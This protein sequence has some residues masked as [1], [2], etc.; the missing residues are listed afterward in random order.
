MI[1]YKFTNDGYP[2][3]TETIVASVTH[4]RLLLSFTSLKNKIRALWNELNT[5][6]KYL[7][8]KTAVCGVIRGSTV[9]GPPQPKYFFHWCDSHAQVWLFTLWVRHE[10]RFQVWVSQLFVSV[11][12]E[13]SKVCVCLCPC[14][15]SSPGCYPPCSHTWGQTFCPGKYWWRSPRWPLRR[16]RLSRLRT[17]WHL[18]LEGL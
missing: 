14:V 9:G 15:Y 10:P 13:Y 5:W 12:F 6:N 1:N 4:Q 16:R 3:V 2:S 7:K 18:E 8:R 17:M 11:P